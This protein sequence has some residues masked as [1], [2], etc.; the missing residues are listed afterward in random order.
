MVFLILCSTP[1][2]YLVQGWPLPMCFFPYYSSSLFTFV[3]L[4]NFFLRTTK[5]VSRQ[6]LVMLFYYASWTPFP[7]TISAKQLYCSVSIQLSGWDSVCQ[8]KKTI[9]TDIECR[10]KSKWVLLDYHIKY[11]LYYT[12]PYWLFCLIF[13]CS[14]LS[15]I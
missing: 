6:K 15:Y 2:L 3:H 7:A 8:M 12:F 1:V 4:T 10:F 14:A 9:D 11:F 5:F 13:G